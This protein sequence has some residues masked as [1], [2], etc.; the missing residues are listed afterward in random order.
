[1]KDKTNFDDQINKKISKNPSFKDILEEVRVAN[2]NNHSLATSAQIS[3]FYLKE[4]IVSKPKRSLFQRFNRWMVECKIPLVLV[5]TDYKR[6][7]SPITLIM[8]IMIPV[9]GWLYIFASILETICFKL[10]V[11]S[12]HV[13]MFWLGPDNE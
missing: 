4:Q 2:N 1:M 9:L 10:K 3:N 13:K 12:K 8:C 7:F 11:N 6:F 5:Y